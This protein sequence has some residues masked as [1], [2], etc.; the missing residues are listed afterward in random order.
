MKKK[1]NKC[2]KTLPTSQF[3]KDSSSSDGFLGSCKECAKAYK[4]EYKNREKN[5][6]KKNRL[7][8]KATVWT[9]DTMLKILEGLK[10]WLINADLKSDEP[11]ENIFVG[12][13]FSKIGTSTNIF[14]NKLELFPWLRDEYE[15]LREIQQFKLLKLGLYR[16][17]DSGLTKFVLANMHD[18]KEKSSNDT[19]LTLEGLDIRD[20][21]S[22]DEDDKE[23]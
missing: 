16:K 10:T 17:T 5:T 11:D 14:T 2:A 6:P 9:E 4:K 19:S 7:N 22:F 15:R 12:D 8:S 3:Y 23:N 20:L 21:V 13:Y 1:C 18:W